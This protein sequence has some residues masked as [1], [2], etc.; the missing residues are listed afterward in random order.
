MEIQRLLLLEAVQVVLLEWSRN[1]EKK[2]KEQHTEI[3][4]SSN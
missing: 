2:E 4:V 1:S 3:I